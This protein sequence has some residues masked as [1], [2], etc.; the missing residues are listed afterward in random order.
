MTTNSPGSF[1]EI[2]ADDVLGFLT[3]H[4]TW[5]EYRPWMDGGT[6]HPPTPDACG[7]CGEP[8][9][10][11]PRPCINLGW[12]ATRELARMVASANGGTDG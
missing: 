8:K 11:H 2:R 10:E 7:D 1:G 4:L 5:H 6:R 9:A 12:R 3:D